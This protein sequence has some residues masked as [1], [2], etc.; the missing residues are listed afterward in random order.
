MKKTIRQWL[1]T[2]PEPYRAMA[3][4]NADVEDLD[5]EFESLPEAIQEAFYWHK[6]PEGAEF[7]SDVLIWAEDGPRLPPIPPE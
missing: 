7:W 4:K 5:N 1:S 2:L 3:L 6:T